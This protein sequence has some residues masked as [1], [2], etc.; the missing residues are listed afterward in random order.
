MVSDLLLYPDLAGRVALGAMSPLL[1][2]LLAMAAM[3]VGSIVG[4]IVAQVT[5]IDAYVAIPML[6]GLIVAYVIIAINPRR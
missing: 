3:A 5:G 4:L 6:I 2:W 1:M